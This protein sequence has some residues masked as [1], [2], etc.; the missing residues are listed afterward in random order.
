[1]RDVSAETFWHIFNLKICEFGFFLLSAS[2]SMHVLNDLHT[3]ICMYTVCIL[4]LSMLFYFRREVLLNLFTH[5]A[6]KFFVM[7]SHGFIAEVTN[8]YNSK[9]NICPMLRMFD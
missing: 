1:M 5:S 6:D 7:N 2:M 4:C 3:Y 8:I 9:N